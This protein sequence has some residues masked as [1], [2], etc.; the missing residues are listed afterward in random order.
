MAGQQLA[1][2]VV[3]V[4]H[5]PVQNFHRRHDKA[6]GAEAALNGRFLHKGLLDVGQLAVGAHEAL[7]GGDVLALGP[8]GQVQAGVVALAVDEHVAGAAFAHLAALFHG[9]HGE[10]VAEHIRQRC[11]DVHHFLHFLAVEE[12]RHQLIL[13]L[14]HY[15]SPPASFTDSMRQ[16]LALST[17]MWERKALLAR[18]ES[19]GWMSS[20]TVRP[21][22]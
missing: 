18:Q 7:Q 12:E 16:R 22:C 8:H 5:T 4:V 11:P 17:A 19:R 6:R 14:C 3:G 10:V 15:S 21:N 13:I 1:Q 9:G 2:L 20:S